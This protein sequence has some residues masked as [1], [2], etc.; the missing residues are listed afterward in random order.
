MLGE[1]VTNWKVTA[2]SEICFQIFST[3]E[4]ANMFDS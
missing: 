1:L 4:A 3:T 2:E